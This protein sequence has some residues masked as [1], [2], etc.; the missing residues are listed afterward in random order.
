MRVELIFTFVP[1]L[2]PYQPVNP[3]PQKLKTVFYNADT[4]LVALLKGGDKTAFKELFDKYG[5]RLYQ[6]SLKFLREKE[7]AEDLLNEVFLKIWENRR[8]LKTDTSFQSYLFTIAYNNIRQRFLKRSREEKYIQIFAT[9][10]LTENL[11][12]EDQIDYL[13]FVKVV[14]DAIEM[15]P[16][17]RREIFLLYYKEELKSKQIAEKLNITEQFVRNQLTIAKKTI[18]DKFKETNKLEGMLFFSLFIAHN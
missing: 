7:D 16:A 15:L 6:F 10:H 17:R 14:N 13:S 1:R 18:I 11:K 5:K 4:E 2:S 9:E 12:N 8:N 3:K